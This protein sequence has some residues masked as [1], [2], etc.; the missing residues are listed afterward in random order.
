MTQ[1]TTDTTIDRPRDQFELRSQ[2]L[3]ALPIVCHFLARIG[4]ET[5]V[6][7]H[8]AA[9]QER[10][11]LS[12]VRSIGVLVRNLA[13]SH[14]PLYGLSE[15][16]AGFEPRLL[17][18]ASGE[19]E[20]IND[21]R[22]GRALDRLFE[23]DRA[24]LITELMLGVIAEFEI[25]TSQLHNDS[26][27]VSLHG[28]YATADGFERA[29]RPTPAI[30]FGH[31]KDHR[32]DL[33]QLV[34]ILTV[35]CD[36]AVPI[37]YRLC[38]G[39]TADVATHIR[40]WEELCRL[41][42]RADFLYVADSKLAAHETMAHIDR[43]GGRFVTVLPRSRNEDG[44]LRKWMQ[45]HEPEWVEAARSPGRRR[46]DPDDV[47]S[48]APPPLTSAEGYR[49][50]WVH[51]TRKRELDRQARSDCIAR[52]L[53]ALDS[54]N[55]RL[56][57]PKCRFHKRAAVEQAARQALVRTKAARLVGFEVSEDLEERIRESSRGS[58]RKPRR[59]RYTR[60]RFTLH[61]HLDEAAVAREAACDGCF[62]PISNDRR[63]TDAELLVA[64]RY[65]PNLE[66]RHHQLKSVQDAAPVFLKSAARIE[67]LFTCHFLALL[68]SCL[69]ERELR[70][71]MA[72]E[73]I[74][75]LALYPEER[76]CRAPTAARVFELFADVARH[77]LLDDG[78][79]VQV[80]EPQL[81]AMQ[82]QVLDL[83]GIPEGAYRSAAPCRS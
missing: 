26:T 42:G 12:A 41:V 78:E 47:W 3:G 58:G 66:K 77:H 30:A 9:G 15:W 45:D 65:Q 18:L 51:S 2:T 14:V 10:A 32:P 35:A 48:V 17:G 61:W 20:L 79:L 19:I 43:L 70:R 40:T 23:S 73:G 68:C 21:D 13:I 38:D 50:V 75:R 81:T 7:R 25:D 57:G 60:A 27:S 5:L 64:Y 56:A 53:H 55:Q 1:A 39:N 36:G 49:I 11:A 31:S 22:A 6:E 82:K 69:I 33:K 71:A 24:S 34:W 80:F 63:L 44:L 83:L 74:E 8:L 37:A 29:G 16:A 59:R 54:L 4:V 76:D 28:A 52:G 72:S 46:A 62:P 67:A